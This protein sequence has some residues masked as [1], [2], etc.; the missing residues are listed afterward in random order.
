MYRYPVENAYSAFLNAHGGSS[1]A[2]TSQQ[3]TVYYFDVQNNSFEEALDMFSSFFTCPLFNAD[4]TNREITAVDNENTKNLQSD[5]WRIYQL[6]K[7]FSNSDH[8]YHY[9]STGNAQTLRTTPESMGINIR[10]LLLQWYDA[11]YSAN[12]MKL[13]V[14][15]SDSLD[16]MQQWVEQKFSN[17]KNH[18]YPIP[19]FPQ[20]AY[21]VDELG[22]MIEV[23]PVRDV[24]QVEFYFV[25]P[26][27][28]CHYLTKPTRYLSHLIGHESEGSI[29]SA[30]KAKGWANSLSSSDYDAIKEFSYLCISIDLTTEGLQ[31]VNEVIQC[32]YAYINMLKSTGCQQWIADEVKNIADMNFRFINKSEPSDYVTNIANQMQ[33]YPT[34]H[35]G[36]CLYIYTCCVYIQLL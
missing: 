28:D 34:E 23:V 16:T 7:S 20:Q 4:S 13:A 1:N 35:I 12:L 8:P 6:L 19:S 32:V 26:P 18:T 31:H 3:N 17:I 22:R 11:H 9:F 30:L 15:G 10:D 2:Y 24:K 29:L 21:T 14:Y 25:L 27:T 36:M 5:T 33:L